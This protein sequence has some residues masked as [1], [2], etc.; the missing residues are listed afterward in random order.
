V[1]PGKRCDVE[2]SILSAVFPLRFWCVS[3][4]PKISSFGM[5]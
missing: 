3:M 4:C 5:L 1:S 2:I